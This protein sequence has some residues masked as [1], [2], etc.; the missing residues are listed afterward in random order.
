MTN[1]EST[2]R[3]AYSQES[4]LTS[5]LVRIPIIWNPT[6]PNV[7]P[8]PTVA[9]LLPKLAL[10]AC[11]YGEGMAVDSERNGLT[12]ADRIAGNGRAVR[13]QGRKVRVRELPAKDISRVEGVG[14]GG[15][16]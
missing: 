2:I 15:V 9:I 8:R 12:L 13:R 4:H 10:A 14:F 7:A 6:R 5:P 16:I 1:E 3:P 11:A